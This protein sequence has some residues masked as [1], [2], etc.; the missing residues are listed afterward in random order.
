MKRLALTITLVTWL[1]L[2]GCSQSN[3][4]LNTPPET[5]EASHYQQPQSEPANQ[6]QPPIVEEE[7]C[8]PVTSEYTL[9]ATPIKTEEP[10]SKPE[11]PILAG[12]QPASTR[13]WISPGKVEVGN[14][15]A[16]ARAE[17]VLIVNNGLDTDVRKY[18]VTTDKNDNTA[19]IKL[20]YP[21]YKDSLGFLIEVASSNEADNPEAT[22]Y[23]ADVQTL[24]VTG[25]VPSAERIVGVVYQYGMERKFNISYEE[26]HHIKEPYAMPPEEAKD[27]VIIA[28][29]TPVLAPEQ[30]KEILVALVMP[31][32]AE[33]PPKWEFWVLV[34]RKTEGTVQTNLAS[35]WLV[36]MRIED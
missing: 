1:L 7:P 25:F 34:S 6:E 35:R 17:W 14:F 22:G 28:D 30:S 27:W 18:K 23:D 20:E 32:K 9:K 4:Q 16:G 26:P 8:E 24:T 3:P 36:N 10:E 2:T 29:S 13:T 12:G 21:L 19:L 15:H 5:E 11:E 31:E 33:A